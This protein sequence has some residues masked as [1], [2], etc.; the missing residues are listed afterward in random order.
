MVQ[1]AVEGV[2]PVDVGHFWAKPM[3]GWWFQT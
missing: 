3:A 1:N 2:V